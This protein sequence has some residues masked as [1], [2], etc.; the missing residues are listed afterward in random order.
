MK[1]SKTSKLIIILQL[2][3]ITDTPL[4]R[5]ILADSF[6]FTCPDTENMRFLPPLQYYGGKLN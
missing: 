5:S 6:G 4:M 1:V 2:I 3:E